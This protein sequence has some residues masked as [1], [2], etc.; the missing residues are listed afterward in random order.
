MKLTRYLHRAVGAAAAILLLVAG[1]SDP[2]APLVE[3]YTGVN[4]LVVN[5]ITFILPDNSIKTYTNLRIDFGKS[6]AEY[7]DAQDIQRA[8][9]LENYTLERRE[10]TVTLALPANASGP[11]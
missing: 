10:V 2:V 5:P 1:C 6:S 8:I 7:M 9:R 4:G 3:P 11:G